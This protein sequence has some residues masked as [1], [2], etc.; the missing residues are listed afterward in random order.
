[1]N[2]GLEV[3]E[4]GIQVRATEA[5]ANR[6]IRGAGGTKPWYCLFLLGSEAFGK[7]KQTTWRQLC[8]RG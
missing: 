3:V 1:M 4:N 7:Y 6:V 8:Q 5:G 2:D